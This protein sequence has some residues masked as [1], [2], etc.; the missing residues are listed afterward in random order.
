MKITPIQT[1]QVQIKSR[2]LEPRFAA[3]PARIVDI[4]A[5]RNWSARLPIRCFAIE[6]PE[7]L[8]VIDTGESSH[9]KD[10]GY[11]PRWQLFANTCERTWVQPDEES[12]PQLLGLG[13]DPAAVRWLVMTHMH[14]DHAGGL[15]HF[16]DAEIL[17]TATE[18]EMALA[19]NGPANGYFNSHYPPWFS[20]RTVTFEGDPWEGFT[21]SIPLT[22][23]RAVRLLPTPGHTAGHMSV[24][25]EEDD[26]LVLL[27]GD[28]TY[29]EGALLAGRIDGVVQDARAHR[30]STAQL[31]DLCRRHN[32][33]VVPT[34]DPEG[35]SRLAGRRF[36]EV[37]DASERE[38]AAAR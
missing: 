28:A 14:G 33:V 30:R 2:H 27:S 22:A 34:H 23:D 8:I 29:S 4:L 20:P 15:A 3:R 6:H 18:A 35:A 13:L 9:S 19:R 25:I 11:A 12:G 36:T 21:A 26:H 31:R 1:G 38:G 16:P 7:G 24:V 17:L 10:P 37:G 5:D 32:V